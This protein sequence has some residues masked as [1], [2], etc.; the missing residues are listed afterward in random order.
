MVGI[1]FYLVRL[2][3]CVIKLFDGIFHVL[4]SHVFDDTRAILEDVSKANVTSISHVV[5]QVLPATSWRQSFNK[6]H[7]LVYTKAK[8]ITDSCLPETTTRY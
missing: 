6:R 3:L 1:T 7:K 2:E 8:A 5:L 4:V